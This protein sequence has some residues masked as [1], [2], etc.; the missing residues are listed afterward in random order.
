MQPKEWVITPKGILELKEI[1]SFCKAG[2]LEGTGK[3]LGHSVFR[4]D[5]NCWE[6]YVR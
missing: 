5:T 2:S 1:L 4:R 6:G 3:S